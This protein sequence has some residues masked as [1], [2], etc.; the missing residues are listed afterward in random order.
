MVSIGAAVGAIAFSG[1]CLLAAGMIC[2]NPDDVVGTSNNPFQFI[3]NLIQGDNACEGL[4][5][6]FEWL[7][8]I[9]CTVPLL[10]V[11][12]EFMEPLFNNAV[13][14]TIA[15]AVAVLAFLGILI[16]FMF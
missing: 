8:F 7:L 3:I 15:G 6:W 10:F 2:G 12:W 13:T 9:L 5:A 11:L 1:L 14:G 16:A 4:P